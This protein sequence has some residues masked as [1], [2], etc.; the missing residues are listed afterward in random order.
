MLTASRKDW[1]N[2]SVCSTAS[3][4]V[5]P[6]GLRRGSASFPA[7][8][9]PRLQPSQPASPSITALTTSG[10]ATMSG[11]RVFVRIRPFLPHEAES[12]DRSYPLPPVEL[13]GAGECLFLDLATGIPREIFHFD[14]C[15]C[16]ITK[17]QWENMTDLVSLPKES[18]P[19]F[20]DCASQ[21]DL[22]HA[23]G[24]PI[25]DAVMEGFNASILA[26]G[27][28]SSGKT[29]TMMG[30]PSSE[31]LIPRISR[32]IMMEAATRTI[33]QERPPQQQGAVVP[34]SAAVSSPASQSGPLF[35]SAAPLQGSLPPKTPNSNSAILYREFSMEMSF[36]EIYNEQ[37][38]DLLQHGVS[39]QHRRRKVRVHPVLG[40]YVEGLTYERVSGWQQCLK[41]LQRGLQLRHTAATKMNESSSRSHAIFQLRLVQTE[42]TDVG[43]VQR[44]SNVYLADLAGSERIKL[45]AV[46]GE[47]LK[48]AA[49]INLS[50]TT[51]RRVI[52]AL[53]QEKNG[54]SMTGNS[55]TAQQQQQQQTSMSVGPSLN[56]NNN[57][58]MIPYRDSMLTWVLSES[59]GGNAKACMVATLCPHPSYVEETYQTLQYANRAKSIVNTVV[60]NEDQMAKMIRQLQDALANAKS[61]GTFGG[62]PSL[63]SQPSDVLNGSMTASPIVLPSAAQL[64]RDEDL[65]LIESLRDEQM[66]M[67]TRYA[68]LKDAYDALKDDVAREQDER[69]RLSSVCQRQKATIQSLTSASTELEERIASLSADRERQDMALAAARQ[70]VHRLQQHIAMVE[71]EKRQLED[72]IRAVSQQRDSFAEEQH[73]TANAMRKLEEECASTTQR[74]RIYTMAQAGALD[75]MQRWFQATIQ[76]AW[77]ACFTSKRAQLLAH[78]T[79]S[80]C[81]W[82]TRSVRDAAHLTDRV[83]KMTERIVDLEFINESQDK[84]LTQVATSY[85]EVREFLHRVEK[86]GGVGAG[87]ASHF[88][89]AEASWTVPSILSALHRF[90]AQCKQSPT[91]H[92][93]MMANFPAQASSPCRSPLPPTPNLKA[94][95][96]SPFTPGR[97]SSPS[98][99]TTPASLSRRKF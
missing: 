41:F 22:F 27:Q 10:E 44:R 83:Q 73:H 80:S 13:R 14:G 66:L 76:C 64:P 96:P 78:V 17:K 63:I 84:A 93:R 82:A 18:L 30:T 87:A 79:N 55:S 57:R 8:G 43:P 49:Q 50:L 21:E 60:K 35:E 20:P 59:L 67:L 89:G 15:F 97:S 36:F 85:V 3:A 62:V 40:V 42:M 77:E 37:V 26:Y 86:Q 56:N 9:S 90:C 19:T 52:D 34:P 61:A 92:V 6:L 48:E 11:Y 68:D 65:Q 39:V 2:A 72:E 12:S 88:Q 4:N 47:R 69:H 33:S 7:A 1:D 23:V 53:I 5:R 38:L 71:A 58:L 99:V 29:F 95:S 75:H 32:A 98:V 91:V 54:G 45:S 25:V 16:S 74:H 81:D 24:K 46:E 94:P 70:E 28:T 51:L 31:G